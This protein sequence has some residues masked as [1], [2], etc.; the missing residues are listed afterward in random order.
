[1]LGMGSFAMGEL[2]STQPYV[3]GV[4]YIDRMSHYGRRCAIDPKRS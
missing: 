1:M 4:G 2:M 3:S